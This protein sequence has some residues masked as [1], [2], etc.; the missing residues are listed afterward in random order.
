MKSG[1]FSAAIIAA[2]LVIG[3]SGASAF[4]I[5]PAE[6]N[7]DGTT[8]FADPDQRTQN[9]ANSYQSRN[10]QNTMTFGHTTLQFGSTS[11]NS[12]PSP[13]LQEKFLQSP[14]SRTVPSQGW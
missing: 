7:P 2:G 14:A 1:L 10:G 6:T 5:V 12:G 8:K 13:A 4:Q 9:L 3:A 11:S